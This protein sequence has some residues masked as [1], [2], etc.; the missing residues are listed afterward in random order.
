MNDVRFVWEQLPP[1]QPP[2][3]FILAV[4]S[5]E[6]IKDGSCQIYRPA[7]MDEPLVFK[8]MGRPYVQTSTFPRLSRGECTLLV[9]FRVPN[10]KIH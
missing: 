7:D 10:L 3:L 9:S 2:T 6:R 4:R 1:S 8:I 5:H